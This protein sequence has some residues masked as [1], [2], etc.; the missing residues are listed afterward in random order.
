MRIYNFSA[1][2]STLPIEVLEKV[3]ADFLDYEGC[4]MSV[5]EISHRGKI[6]EKINSEAKR[7]LR[8]LMNIPDNYKVLAR[9]F[10]FFDSAVHS[11][12]VEDDRQISVSFNDW[13]F[14]Q[15]GVVI[16]FAPKSAAD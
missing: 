12:I 9:A 11:P 16:T 2:P 1:G 3:K 8:K 6:F 10:G 14:P 13:I 15:D 7:N 4:G 5:T